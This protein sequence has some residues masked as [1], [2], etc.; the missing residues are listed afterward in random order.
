[1]AK[2]KKDVWNFPFVFGLKDTVKLSIIKLVETIEMLA[3]I[4]IDNNKKTNS[5]VDCISKRDFDVP[6]KAKMSTL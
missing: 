6:S 3:N 2:P 1:M 5:K 4:K